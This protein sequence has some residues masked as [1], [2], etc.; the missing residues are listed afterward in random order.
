MVP[1]KTEPNP[2]SV[3]IGKLLFQELSSPVLQQRKSV[4]PKLEEVIESSHDRYHAKTTKQHNITVA[5]LET[6]QARTSYRSRSQVSYSGMII[7]WSHVLCY[8]FCWAT[9]RFEAAM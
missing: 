1:L 8:L 5:E 6:K 2:S 7:F 3:P 4:S 9:H